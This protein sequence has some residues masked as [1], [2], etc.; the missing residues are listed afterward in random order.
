MLGW[1]NHCARTGSEGLLC[2]V[3][4]HL[5][6]WQEQARNSSVRSEHKHG[7]W[8]RRGGIADEIPGSHHRQPVDVR[9]DSLISKLSAAANTLCGLL[10]NIGGEGV[11]YT[12][13]SFGP[14]WSSSC[15]SILLL[16]RLQRISESPEDTEQCPTHRRPFWPR[17]PR[18]SFGHWGSR[19]DTPTWE[20][21]TEERTRPT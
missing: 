16:R 3:G 18:G 17:L 20:Y 8:N 6:L 15:R 21:G 13:A 4:G 19:E 2:E 14:E 12:R 7:K 5:V 10:P 1:Y 9:A 11:D